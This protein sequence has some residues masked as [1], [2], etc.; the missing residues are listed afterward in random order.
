V[1]KHKKFIILIFWM[2]LAILALVVI[3]LLIRPD[4]LTSQEGIG[5]LILAAV[6][7]V[8]GIGPN[9]YSLWKDTHEPPSR[10]VDE[11][12][13]HI[14]PLH[15]LPDQPRDFIGRAVELDELCA[16]ARSR[17][18]LISG[19]GGVGKTALGLVLAHRL[20][21]QYPDAQLFLNLQGASDH[22]LTPAEALERLIRAFKPNARLPETLDELK[23]IYT[24]LL[25]GKRVLVFLDDA[26]DAA[27][28][29]PLLPP[30]P[31]LVIVTSRHRL[32]LA[33]LHATDVE[34]LPPEDADRLICAVWGKT[35][36]VRALAGQ[37]GRLPMALRA[38]GALL[39]R[40][41]DL[42][43]AKVQQLLENTAERLKL[44]DPE[45]ATTVAAAFQA[46]Y[47]QLD[48]A[49]QTRWREL[50]IFPADF[51]T[52]AAA[53]VWQMDGDAGAVLAEL[54]DACLVDYTHDRWRLHD[55]GRDFTRSL[56]TGEEGNALAFRHASH[57]LEVLGEAQHLYE[58]GRDSI[59]AGLGLFDRERQNVEAGQAWAAARAGQNREIARLC[60]AYPDA[61]GYVISLRLHPRAWIAW[62]EAALAA[63]RSLGDRRGEGNALT[64]LGAAYY[65][66]GEVR[67]AIGYYEEALKIKREIGDRRG[68]GNALGNLGLAYADLGEVQ[69]AIGYHEESL[70]IKREIGDR[71][72]E[73]NALGNLGAAYYSLGEV[74]K[75]IGY[76][77]EALVIARELGDRRGEG[78]DLGNLGLAYADLGEVQKAIGFYEQVLV[79][80]RELGDRQGEGNALGNLG[81]AYARLGEVQRAIGYYEEALK[82]MRKIGDRRGEGNALGSLGLAYAALGEVQKAIGYYEQALVIAREIGDRRGEGNALGSLGLAYADLGEV[83]KAIGYYEQQLTIT[84]EIGD[85]R[86]EGI[87]LGNLG[88]AYAR[89]SEVQKAIGYYEEALKIDREIGDRRG[90]GT[91]L[92]NLGI[93]YK[94]LGEV[95][96]AIGYYEEALKIKREIGDRR[97]EAIDSWNLG[98]IYGKQGDLARAVEL[99]Q[100]CVDYERAIG[101]PDA[102]KDA[103]RVEE[104]RRRMAGG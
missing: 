40:R 100:V 70:K 14:T 87:A 15:Q 76:Y 18:V 94:N 1:G 57:Y 83:Q 69:K 65:S 7:A 93:A 73:G 2:G 64:N 98:L 32:V 85:R 47:D 22:P 8:L 60:N 12:S 63:A 66:L 34:A 78:A 21:E 88:L 53:A 20:R 11:N 61:G 10:E 72:G 3:S 97:G 30:Q 90:E 24:T 17:G 5:G 29:R 51:D 91:A 16:N 44:A 95:R 25:Q 49:L 4:W 103:A 9:L 75:A 37:C 27:Q 56:W 80:F 43:V 23:A 74:Q 96:K 48:P 92:G 89:L 41:P 101:D 26:M 77:E 67:K 45:R 71:R 59:L 33:S 6:V 46:S 104:I 102:E 50:G 19:T 68:E 36:D 38:V 39:S 84:R 62:L 42:S 31:C 81:I 86:G 82:I 28:V 13:S 99:M 35:G 55:L 79:I 54:R 58:T 52:P